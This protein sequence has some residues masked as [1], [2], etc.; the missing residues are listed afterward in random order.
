[1]IMG[2]IG[3]DKITQ[4]EHIKLFKSGPRASVT[5][6]YLTNYVVFTVSFT[7]NSFNSLNNQMRQICYFPYFTEEKTLRE[8][9]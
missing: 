5:W 9:K 6:S 7:V 2:T 1:M 3:L 8:V 4:G